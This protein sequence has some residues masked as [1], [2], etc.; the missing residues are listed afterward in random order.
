[1]AGERVPLGGVARWTSGGTPTASNSAYYGGDIPWVTITDMT[2]GFV[3]DSTKKLTEAGLASI[4][5]GLAPTGS[6]LC[7]MYGTI[8]KTAMVESPLATNQAIA[9]GVPD[10]NKVI[11]EYLYNAVREKAGELDAYGRGATQRNINRAQLE[12]TLVWVPELSEQRRI[13]D[14]LSSADSMVDALSAELEA[15][16]D[17]YSQLVDAQLA[18]VERRARIGSVVS[19][20]TDTFTISDD[21]LYTQVTVSGKGRGMRLR[22]Q[23]LGRDIGTKRQRAISAGELIVSK[24]GASDGASCVVPEEFAGAVVTQD[25]PTFSI[26][27]EKALPEYLDLVVRT[28]L[29]ARMCADITNGTGQGRVDMKRFPDLKIPLPTLAEQAEIVATMGASAARVASAS[30]HLDAAKLL[31][32][33]LLHDLLSGTHRIPESYDRL[34]GDAKGVM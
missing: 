17:L 24:L 6:V 8:G 34:L 14:L 15:A 20:R 26:S 9:V 16:Q 5:G 1:M 21:V 11:P 27:D 33:Q 31:R 7:S 18:S 2:S 12:A 29:F 13:V 28:G 32:D 25:F 10:R 19:P 22:E 30:S 23:K 3:S 4:G